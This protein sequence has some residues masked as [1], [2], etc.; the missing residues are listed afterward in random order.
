[1]G[2]AAR[3]SK[4]KTVEI[5]APLAP[6]STRKSRSVRRIAIYAVIAAAV[7]AIVVPVALWARYRVGYVVSRNALVKG[8]VADIGIQASGV[9][10]SVD[11]DAGDEVKAGQILARLEDGQLKARVERAKSQ[12]DRATLTLEV[13]HS[14]IAHERRRLASLVS[15]ASAR[16]AAAK[17]QSEA[18][19]TRAEDAKDKYAL[20]QSLAEAGVIPPEELRSA[21]TTRRTANAD[22]ATAQADQKAAEAGHRLAQ[23]ESEGLS[24]REQHL[25]VLEAEIAA[26]RAEL[27]LAEADL[28]ATLIRAP[29]DGWVIRRAVQPGASVVQGQ[30]VFSLWLG[31]QL[32]VEAWIDETDLA[33][34]EVGSPAR[35]TLNSHPD[36]VFAG[37]VESIGVSTDYEMPDA[38]VPQPRNERMRTTPVVC[39][40]I[41]LESPEGLLPGLSAVVGIRKK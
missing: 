35:V 14:S 9:V 30:P 4:L 6:S 36:R 41:R 15:E 22:G 21:D 8:Y 32:W 37:V 20:R 25:V 26:Y 31:K 28:Q 24:V 1:M 12:L 39:V 16:V 33:Y 23:V 7:L 29:E 34:M 10:T 3:R 5:P 11:V 13:E 17:A 27:A 18:A 38:D 40:R 2:S 19:Q